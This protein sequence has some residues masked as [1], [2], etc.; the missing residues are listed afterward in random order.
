MEFVLGKEC[1]MSATAITPLDGREVVEC[2]NC[3]LVQFRTSDSTCRKCHKPLPVRVMPAPAPRLV[4]LVA[5]LPEVFRNVRLKR[6]LSQK[7][8]GKQVGTYRSHI[9]GIEIGKNIPNFLTLQRYAWALGTRGSSLAARIENP[10]A[11]LVK[12]FK[13][14]DEAAI[15]REVG[16]TLRR[17]R[18]VIRK[19]QKELADMLGL[20]SPQICRLERGYSI[21]RLGFFE[22]FAPAVNQPV[23]A[24]FAEIENAAFPDESIPVIQ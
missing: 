5:C 18:E 17:L 8:L 14:F 22:N 9:S 6:H 13:H 3:K 1:A 7:S 16:P 21:P 4:E 11:P 19:S 10:L 24:I 23:S 2:D 20:K 15:A 12:A